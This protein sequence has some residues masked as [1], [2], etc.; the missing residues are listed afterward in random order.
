[1]EALRLADAPPNLEYRA[2]AS[3]LGWLPWVK[4]GQDAGTTG[5]SRPIEAVEFRW[6]GPHEGLKLLARCHVA[7]LGTLAC[8]EAN[9][10]VVIGT[11]GQNLRMEGVQFIL[12]GVAKTDV[13]AYFA[14]TVSLA[15]LKA[16]TKD[17]KNE[18]EF[19]KAIGKV[20]N[21]SD[22]PDLA[23]NLK[24]AV[25]KFEA[26]VGEAIAPEPGMDAHGNFDATD[27]ERHLGGPGAK[28][29]PQQTDHQNAAGER[30]EPDMK[31]GKEK[32]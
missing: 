27:W 10:G 1:M 32:V 15:Q 8:K 11:M 12:V 23:S 6:V 20:M 13:P 17:F 31:E 21:S 26:T 2:F 19:A 9:E 18:I 30:L 4:P 28:L 5:Q 16:W 25:E 24:D 22:L 29:D 3:G 7:N 14:S